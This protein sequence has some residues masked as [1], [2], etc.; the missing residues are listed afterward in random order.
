MRYNRPVR[1]ASGSR[2]VVLGALLVLGVTGCG[3]LADWIPH[4]DSEHTAYDKVFNSSGPHVYGGLRLDLV[5]GD[6]DYWG[7]HLAPVA[8]CFWIDFLI[9]TALDT[10]LLPFTLPYSLVEEGPDYITVDRA[11]FN[12]WIDQK[13]LERDRERRSLYYLGSE[14]D[15]HYFLLSRFSSGRYDLGRARYRIRNVELPLEKTYPYVAEE[16]RRSVLPSLPP[17]RAR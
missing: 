16:P 2:A 6:P 7:G 5:L 4:S 11:G 9:S 14:G 8:F 13:D 1:R 3:T 10:A 15:Y 12:D 17:A